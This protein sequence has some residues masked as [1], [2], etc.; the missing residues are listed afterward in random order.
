MY[1]CSTSYCPSRRCNQFSFYFSQ[2]GQNTIDCLSMLL[3]KHCSIVILIIY[4]MNLNIYLNRLFIK[5]S[6]LYINIFVILML[7]FFESP[8][9]L[10]I[11]SDISKPKDFLIK[12]EFPCGILETID[13][14]CLLFFVCDAFVKVIT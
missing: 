6:I 13:I 7:A 4:I 8:S 10:S 12:Y 14:F 9:S 11:T 5:L 1:I 3:H 2:N